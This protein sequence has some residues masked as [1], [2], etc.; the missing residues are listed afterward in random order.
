MNTIMGHAILRDIIIIFAVSVPVVLLAHKLRFPAIVGFLVTG[1]I[2]GPH[3]LGFIPD[4]QE[5]QVLAEVGVALLLFSIGLEFSFE[6]LRG[7][8]QTAIGMGFMQVALTVLAGIGLGYVSGLDWI[9]SAF[10]GCAIAL[11]STA[12]VLSILSQ[13]RWYDAPAGRISTGILL[14]QDL[15]VIPMIVILQF[16]SGASAASPLVSLGWALVHLAGLALA[17]FVLSRWVL[18]PILHHISMPRSKELFVVVVVGIAIGASYATQQMGLSFAVG[19]FLAGIL[20][21]TTEFRFHALSEIAPFRYCFN[22]LFFVALGMIVNPSFVV[23]HIS[24][25]ALL[26]VFILIVKMAIVGGTIIAFGYPLNVSAIGALMLAQVGE[27][28]FML[29]FLGHEAG[30]IGGDFYHL[31]VD[32]AA[33]TM[34]IAPFVV[35]LAPKIGEKLAPYSWKQWAEKRYERD[36]LCDENRCLINHAI[37]CGFG[38]L[39]MTIGQ[40]LEKKGIPYVVLELNPFTAN[41]MKGRDKKIFIG[42]GASADLLLH[43]GIE[44]ARMLAIAVPDYLNALAILKQARQMNADIFIVIRSRYRDQVDRFYDAGA[45]VV[46]CEELEAGIEMGRYVLESLGYVGDEVDDVIRELRAFGSADFF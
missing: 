35:M 44:R 10:L 12:I 24:E 14:F 39:G 6:R 18:N 21:S 5:I 13:K 20:V 32:A 29:V 34:I 23:A 42:D 15:A 31:I 19:A 41:K 8:G 38:P 9:E 1:V 30:A 11:S 16:F 36:P 33:I 43:S 26:V 28:S 22:G 45:D 7:W 40:L 25:V 46:V 4:I 2:I 27:F 37:I 17:L 3:A